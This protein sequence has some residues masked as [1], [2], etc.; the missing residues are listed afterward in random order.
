[1]VDSFGLTTDQVCREK[2]GMEGSHGK[3]LPAICLSTVCASELL[4]STRSHAPLLPYVVRARTHAGA[5][6]GADADERPGAPSRD[7]LGGVQR[8]VLLL[9][10]PG[11]HQDQGPQHAQGTPMGCAFVRVA[12][13]GE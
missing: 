3:V 6:P 1:M 7:P 13:K 9:P 10:L 8:R 11:G 5:G 12:G 2:S 4:H